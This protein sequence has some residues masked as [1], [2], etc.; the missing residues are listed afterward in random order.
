MIKNKYVYNP[1][2]LRYEKVHNARQKTIRNLVAALLLLL[3]LTA[4]IYLLSSDF[5]G[6]SRQQKELAEMQK[7]YREMQSH[8]ELMKKTLENLNERDAAISRQLLE[9][10]PGEEFTSRKVKSPEDLK[11]LKDTELIGELSDN[12]GKMR[13]KLAVLSKTQA[14]LKS[15]VKAKE[16]MLKA[17]P[18][19]RP[20]ISESKVEYLSGFGYR[21]H[22]VFKILKIHNGI[23][24]GAAIGTAVY[25]SG[26][27]KIQQVQQKKDGYG[28]SIVMDHGY[29]FQ[30]VYAHLSEISVKV[31]DEVKRG[32]IIGRVGNSGGVAPHLHYEVIYKKKRVNPLHFCRE[33][34]TA[35]EFQRFTEMVSKENQALSIH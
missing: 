5:W 26:N 9:S 31:G 20:V 7:Q 3:L 6:N 32:Q 34:M 35:E 8:L 10:E 4:G 27:G 21:K 13:K 17:V 14:E 1:S 23:D 25:A 16:K 28:N 11:Q 30:S 2:T 29:G 15:A 24:F 12:I 33:G 18:S 22:P 19:I